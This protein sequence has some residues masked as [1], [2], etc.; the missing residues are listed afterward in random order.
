MCVT[1]IFQDLCFW[2]SEAR[3]AGRV[4]VIGGKILFYYNM[5]QYTIHFNIQNYICILK[6]K[7]PLV[8]RKA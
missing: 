2:S 5:H 8:D 6:Y 3:I 4:K 7:N 1:Y